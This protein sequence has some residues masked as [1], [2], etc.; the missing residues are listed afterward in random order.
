MIITLD[1]NVLVNALSSN[2]MASF[3]I[4]KLIYDEKVKLALSPP[5]FYEYEDVLN[6][7]KI[8]NKLNLNKTD[9]TKVLGLLA[10]ISEKHAIYYLFRPNLR[11]EKDNIFVELAIK[12]Q[13]DYLITNNIRDFQLNNNLKFDSFKII[14]PSEFV[15]SWRS[16]YEK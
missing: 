13:S 6:R 9:I 3:F 16:K 4:L 7:E 5:V 15:R 12:S 1:T 14:T 10:E 8:L 2:R 11:D